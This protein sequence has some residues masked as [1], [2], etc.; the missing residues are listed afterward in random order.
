VFI[1][2]LS[3]V[4]V[5]RFMFLS[6]TIPLIPD[7]LHLTSIQNTGAGFGL[8]RGQQ[9]L[10]ILVSLLVVGVILYHLPVFMRERKGVVPFALLWGGALGNLIDRVYF[11]Y[12]VDFLDFRIWPVFNIADSAITIGA[13]WLIILYW[14]E[15]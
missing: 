5:E 4:L 6:Q 10:L 3:K 8:L 12:V 1:D 15:K 14:K 11:G 13:V 9:S 2:R 7:V